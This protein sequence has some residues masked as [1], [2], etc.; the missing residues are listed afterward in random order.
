MPIGPRFLN[1][2]LQALI[3]LLHKR[4]PKV[5]LFPSSFPLELL[6]TFFSFYQLSINLQGRRLLILSTTSNRQ[7]LADMDALDAFASS[8]RVPALS[9]LREI[10][11]VLRDV[12]LFSSKDEEGR[13]MTLLQ[14]AGFAE[15]TKVGQLSLGVK[16]LLNVAEMCRQDQDGA[17]EKLVTSL[18]EMGYM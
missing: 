12:S 18:L 13:A 9:S 11:S 4:P 8:I 16:K 15:E 7:M 6:L 3:V 14:Q 5:C 1:G 17:G 10:S 2:V